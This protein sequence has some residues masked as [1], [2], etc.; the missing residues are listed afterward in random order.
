MRR[1]KLYIATSLDGYIA[2]PNSEIDWLDTGGGLD[3]RYEEFYASIDTTLMGNS[4]YKQ[5]ESF[6]DFPYPE[7]ANYVFTRG[8]PLPDTA[9]VRFVSDDVVVFVRALKKAPGKDIWLG[10]EGQVNT[11]MLNASLIDE[12]VLKR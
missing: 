3:Y 2:G 9:H 4:T 5:V 7:K 12:M 1:L 11:A 10:G 8:A 6:G